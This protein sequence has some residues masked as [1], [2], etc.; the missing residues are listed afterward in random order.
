M[1]FRVLLPG[2]GTRRDC[3]APLR[4]ANTDGRIAAAPSDSRHGT[5]SERR[6]YRGMRYH[7]M[8]APGLAFP[9]PERRRT[10][11]EHEKGH[12]RH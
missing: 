6:H 1:L 10:V 12:D 11:S 2:E 5:H 4:T 8:A 9:V 3:T 7:T